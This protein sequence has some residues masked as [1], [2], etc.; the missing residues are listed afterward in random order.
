MAKI[1]RTKQEI[2]GSQAG[3]RQITA[4]GTAKSENPV[5][6]T[7][8]A[9]IQNSNYLYGWQP[10]LLPDKAP[11]E[12]DMNALFYAIT[13]QLAYLY[14]EGIP[15]YN[16]MTEY[17]NTA[18]VKSTDGTTIYKSLVS[19]NLGNPLNNPTYWQVFFNTNSVENINQELTDLKEYINTEITGLKNYIDAMLSNIQPNIEYKNNGYIC[20][21]N[22][23]LKIQWGYSSSWQRDTRYTNI[24]YPESFTGDFTYRV[25]VSGYNNG[26]SN[27]RSSWVISQNKNGCIAANAQGGIGQN[28]IAIGV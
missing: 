27:D 8:V 19:Q 26:M 9:A 20:K 22:G 4:F 21:F 16:A 18:M 1:S 25:V 3:S 17:S 28:W 6:T 24:T 11:Y 10:A 13:T 2:F 14:Q 7:D 23:G 15:E 5:Y 12:E